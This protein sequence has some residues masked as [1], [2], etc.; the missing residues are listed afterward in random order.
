[1]A[2]GV[3]R[4]RFSR[5]AK[6]PW[7]SK[8]RWG[9][10]EMRSRAPSSHNRQVRGWWGGC[11]RIGSEYRDVWETQDECQRRRCDRRSR[12]HR[13]LTC[14]SPRLV[15]ALMRAKNLPEYTVHAQHDE[16]RPRPSSH[17]A[18]SLDARV[19]EVASIRHGPRCRAHPITLVRSERRSVVGWLKGVAA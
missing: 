1:M 6:R 11:N 17:V 5:C 19:A 4:D 16:E 14:R 18:M 7:Q 2:R 3:D 13:R 12:P 9:R 8:A 10:C 15:D